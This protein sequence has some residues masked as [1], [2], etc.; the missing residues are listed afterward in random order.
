MTWPFSSKCVKTWGWFLLS[1]SFD[2]RT[3]LDLE[4]GAKR[5]SN[6]CCGCATEVGR[7]CHFEF[8]IDSVLRVSAQQCAQV[9]VIRSIYLSLVEGEVMSLLCKIGQIS[10]TAARDLEGQSLFFFSFL[11]TLQIWFQFWNRLKY[12]CWP[13][14]LKCYFCGH[15]SWKDRMCETVK[16][17]I[18]KTNKK[19]CT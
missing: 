5:S 1:L 10:S 3:C 18:K 9:R 4:H 6:T 2:S 17:L 19:T 8:A 16:C 7:F 14:L 15:N 13:T 11:F 12:I